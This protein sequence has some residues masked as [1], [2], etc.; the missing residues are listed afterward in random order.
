M[1]AG[2]LAVV[3]NKNLQRAAEDHA[4]DMASRGYFSHDF[5][6]GVPFGSWIGRYWQGAAGEN[7]ALGYST[8]VAVVAGWMASPG[9]RSNVLG[10]WSVTG[11]AAVARSD[12]ALVWVQT[13]GSGLASG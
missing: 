2:L 11:L 10:S 1:Q 6:P 3:V 8:P 9:H 7:I 12:G 5:P 13:F 4:A